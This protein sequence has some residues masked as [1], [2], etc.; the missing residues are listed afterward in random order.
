MNQLNSIIG[1]PTYDRAERKFLVTAAAPHTEWPVEYEDVDLVIDFLEPVQRG[2]TNQIR[3]TKRSQ[4]GASSYTYSNSI[5]E[6]GGSV[7]VME[8]RLTAR[9]YLALKSHADTTRCTVEQKVRATLNTTDSNGEH[10]GTEQHT[11]SP[12]MHA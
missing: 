2:A 12:S 5:P 11:G 6:E 3:L 4:H 7:S 10:I 9:E 8:R 1:F